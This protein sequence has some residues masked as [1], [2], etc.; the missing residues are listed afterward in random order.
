MPDWTWWSLQVTAALVII[1]SL[2]QYLPIAAAGVAACYYCIQIWESRTIQ[3]WWANRQMRRKAEKIARLRAKE[4]VILAKLEAAGA[5]REAR[6]KAREKV[7][8]ATIKAAAQLIREA[9]ENEQ[10]FTSTPRD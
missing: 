7:E 4:K 5:L 10:K 1:G 6:A 8:E 9:A 2:F 3:H